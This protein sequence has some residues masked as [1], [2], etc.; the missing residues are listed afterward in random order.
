MI[1]LAGIVVESDSRIAG[2]RQIV[3]IGRKTADVDRY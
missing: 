2:T 1:E 3:I